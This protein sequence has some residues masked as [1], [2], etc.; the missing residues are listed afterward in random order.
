MNVYNKTTQTMVVTKKGK[1]LII[2][3]DV[4]E[5]ELCDDIWRYIKEFLFYNSELYWSTIIPARINRF[6]D[7]VFGYHITSHM[8]PSLSHNSSIYDVS[9][10]EDDIKLER[11]IVKAYL[12]D[13]L[14]GTLKVLRTTRLKDAAL[15]YIRHARKVTVE[16]ADHH[17][18]RKYVN[19]LKC[20]GLGPRVPE[21]MWTHYT[22]A[23]DLMKTIEEIETKC[24]K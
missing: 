23:C 7:N 6:A 10:T 15:K 17:L 19:P 4:K 9:F 11:Q 1:K 18:R 8:V 21:T 22:S 12:K 24:R 3:E 13:R 16:R 20:L 5:Y 14:D 2:E